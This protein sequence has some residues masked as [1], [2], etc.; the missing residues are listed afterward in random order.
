M[1]NMLQTSLPENGT[2]DMFHLIEV[3]SVKY[4]EDYK[5]LLTFDNGVRKVVDLR[6]R[7][8]GE[9]FEPLK[10]IEYFKQVSVEPDLGTICWPNEADFA[11]DTLYEIGEELEAD[12]WEGTH[13]YESDE[14]QPHAVS[15][16]YGP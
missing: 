3:S 10:Q 6:N 7:L 2:D 4:L 1:E 12:C 14:N 9:V 13:P 15:A 8:N 16:G 11:P 5:L